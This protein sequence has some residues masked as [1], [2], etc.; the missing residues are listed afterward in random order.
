MYVTSAPTHRCPWQSSFAN[1]SVATG[2]GGRAPPST[3]RGGSTGFAGWR[4]HSSASRSAPIVLSAWSQRA[5]H[6]GDDRA[7][8]SHQQSLAPLAVAG[9]VG[10]RLLE[11]DPVDR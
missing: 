2:R 4:R 9:S 11:H 10:P 5:V 6:H 1:V 3:G 7:I 8:L